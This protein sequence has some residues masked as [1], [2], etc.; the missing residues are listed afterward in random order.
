MV[1][2]QG[3][4]TCYILII[5]YDAVVRLV[6]V[7]TCNVFLL[8]LLLC[9]YPSVATAA[10]V[11]FAAAV[12]HR[13]PGDTIC[14]CGLLHLIPVRSLQSN[15]IF[16]SVP[17]G[18]PVACTASIY[19]RYDT[20]HTFSV[21]TGIPRA[22]AGA[23]PPRRS[24][25][26]KYMYRYVSHVSAIEKSDLEQVLSRKRP[27]SRSGPPFGVLFARRA[28]PCWEHLFV[29]RGC[30]FEPKTRSGL[31]TNTRG[32]CLM[33]PRAEKFISRRKYIPSVFK[34]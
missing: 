20:Y 17:P 27:S 14:C 3:T 16:F 34:S 29:T 25:P 18:I 30:F 10:V 15:T 2:E 32:T 19:L 28:S 8:L 12:R 7:N 31:H 6:Y 23:N 11:L 33:R 26:C 9:Y 1:S 21:I 13:V 4:W 24:P 5:L 22:K